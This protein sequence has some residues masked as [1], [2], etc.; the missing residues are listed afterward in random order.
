MKY[1][2]LYLFFAVF[3]LAACVTTDNTSAE[4]NQN[5][6]RHEIEI[7]AAGTRSE[8][9]LGHLFYKN[10]EIG[11]FFNVI[12]AGDTV[13]EYRIRRRLWDFGGYDKAADTSYAPVSCNARITD[14][15][16]AQGWYVSPITCKKQG[17]PEGWIWIK[18]GDL[19]AFVDPGRIDALVGHYTLPTI[20]GGFM[21]KH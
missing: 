1:C 7:T 10:K 14:A 18:S 6:W 11:A 16:M 12:V 5:N 8:G 20:D 3:I 15:E 2:F 4:N 17:T 13:Y 19:K 21:F 9:Q